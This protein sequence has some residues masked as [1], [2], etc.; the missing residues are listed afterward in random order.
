MAIECALLKI[1]CGTEMR[2]REQMRRPNFDCRKHKFFHH[3]LLAGWS[4][5]DGGMCGC[6]AM[7]WTNATE[8]A[9]SKFGKWFARVRERW[10]VNVC[11]VPHRMK[12]KLPKFDASYSSE[13][14]LLFGLFGSLLRQCSGAEKKKLA[15][16]PE[17]DRQCQKT[18]KCWTI[19]AIGEVR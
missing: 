6:M 11:A 3:P 19:R 2:P 4:S 12:C 14:W 8:C 17:W 10:N 1:A 18:G 7:Y 16:A 5:M 13:S 15:P 9:C